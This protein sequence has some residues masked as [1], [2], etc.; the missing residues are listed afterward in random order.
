MKFRFGLGG[1]VLALLML[2][3]SA[4][5]ATP[6][7]QPAHHPRHRHL[8]VAGSFTDADFCG[9]GMTVEVRAKADLDIYRGERRRRSH[10][11]SRTVFINPANDARV[12]MKSDG[13]LKLRRMDEASGFAIVGSLRGAPAVIRTGEGMDNRFRSRDPGYVLYV[14]HF[15]DEGMFL[16]SE[17]VQNELDTETNRAFR[18]LCRIATHALGL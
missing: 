6:D 12:V 18:R 9:T 4:V 2:P 10:G 5:A 17:V 13:Q 7:S 1:V 3:A 16:S 8:E 14:L 11:V 15:S